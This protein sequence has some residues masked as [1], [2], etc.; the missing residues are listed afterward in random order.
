MKKLVFGLL[1]LIISTYSYSQKYGC[2]DPLSINYD[3]SAT[4]NDGSCLYKTASI[5]PKI[6]WVV[7]SELNETSGLI[8]WKN[9]LWTHVDD[10]DIKIYSVDTS[11]VDNIDFYSLNRTFNKDWEEI[12]QDSNYLYIGDFGNNSSGVRKDLKILRIEKISFLNKNPKIDT[13][14]F[15]Y[16]L[17]TDFN[18]KGSNK[19][20]FDCESFIVTSDSIYLF[21]KEW[22]S[23]K[24]SIYSLPKTP[25]T[26]SA[27]YKAN[28]DVAGLITGATLIENQRLIV[29]TG[30]SSY[31]Q[32]FIVLL[33]DYKYDDFFGGNKRKIS[34]NQAFHQ[35]EGIASID[36]LNY[37]ISNEKFSNSLLTVTPKIHK[38]DLSEFLSNYLNTQKSDIN[39]NNDHKIR[40]YPNP[41]N[42]SIYISFPEEFVGET[43]QI[44]N[45]FGQI[46][47]IGFLKNNPEIISS[48]DIPAG[49]YFI[50]INNKNIIKK[51]QKY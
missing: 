3:S 35:V 17:Q 13:I 34:I 19:T 12:S 49:S 2:T 5:S 40:I 36:G 37:Y 47:N 39:F 26:Y 42:E 4:I 21:T 9:K 33:Y 16:S 25:G 6:N 51:L 30:Y 29:L 15:S 48:K 18:S 7:P 38:L 20:D 11:D 41:T 32:P 46:V 8:F 45:I 28:Y 22:I 50:K 44:L 10:T 27:N 43:Y 24:S 14:N 1:I 23:E 31:L